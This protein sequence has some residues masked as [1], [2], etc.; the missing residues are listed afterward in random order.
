MVTNLKKKKKKRSK[1]KKKAYRKEE[2]VMT[3]QALSLHQ[4]DSEKVST[5]F[6]YA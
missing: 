4:Q 1:I 6:V 5:I 2:G 3:L